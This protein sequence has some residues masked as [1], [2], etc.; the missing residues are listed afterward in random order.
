MGYTLEQMSSDLHRIL[1]AD[2]GPEGRKKV[3]ELV[4][5]ACKDADFD[6]IAG[7]L[8]QGC[9]FGPRCPQR[10]EACDEVPELANRAAFDHTDACHLD[11]VLKRARR[12]TTIH[13]ELIEEAT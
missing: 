1:A 4:S 5:K 12:D 8:P 3:G 2:P 11:P 7:H 13:P 10:F 9:A 6:H